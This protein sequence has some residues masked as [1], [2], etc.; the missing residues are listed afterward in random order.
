MVNNLQTPSL[1]QGTGKGKGDGKR[2]GER[3]GGKEI[4]GRGKLVEGEE[5]AP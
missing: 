3:K 5:C 1:D 2:G 4:G